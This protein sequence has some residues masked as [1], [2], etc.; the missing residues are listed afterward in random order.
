MEKEEG[1]EV[2]KGKK[3][4]KNSVQLYGTDIGSEPHSKASIQTIE[5]K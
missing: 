5:H 3:I 1:G 2:T 4:S